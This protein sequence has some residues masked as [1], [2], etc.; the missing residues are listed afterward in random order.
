MRKPL[1]VADLLDLS[2][3]TPMKS[4]VYDFQTTT[5]PVVPNGNNG[6]VIGKFIFDGFGI[7][8]NDVRTMEITPRYKIRIIDIHVQSKATANLGESVTVSAPVGILTNQLAT[9]AFGGGTPC[10]FVD[11]R[12]CPFFATMGAGFTVD[13][14]ISTSKIKVTSA[15]VTGGCIVTVKFCLIT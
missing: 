11:Y 6:S 2:A 13:P 8:P 10:E 3:V 7:G 14:L 15:G 5:T 9:L 1:E 4:V 12:F